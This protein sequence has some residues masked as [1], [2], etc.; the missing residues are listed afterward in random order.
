MPP[1]PSV[2][3]PPAD[4]IRRRRSSG[5]YLFGGLYAGM[6]IAGFAIGIRAGTPKPT[7]PAR[8]TL[9][10]AKTTPIAPEPEPKA[11]VP[12]PKAPESMPA[13]ANVPDPKPKSELPPE[14]KPEPK[15]EAKME[16]KVEAKKTPPAKPGAEVVFAQVAPVFKEKCIICHGGVEPKG[17]LDLRSAK[18]A[19]AGG[20]NGAG[21]KP[22]DPENS[23]IWQ[24]IRDEVMPPPKK[25]QLTAAEK[26]LIKDWIA[27]GA[28]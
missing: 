26:Q 12:E 13:E 15:T 2:A 22:G 11:S 21:L 28:R 25:P 3:W 5:T 9:V 18:A 1:P 7:P 14:P 24:S 23:L 8:P 27:G 17:G 4:P 6:L 19:L 20:D 10:A 16:P